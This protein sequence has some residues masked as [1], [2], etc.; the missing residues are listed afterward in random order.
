LHFKVTSW[1]WQG[2]DAFSA[3]EGGAAGRFTPSALNVTRLAADQ[4]TPRLFR[5][6]ALGTKYQTLQFFE[7]TSKSLPP[8]EG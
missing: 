5:D 7:E 3:S 1:T 2:D 4:N 8:H 6:I